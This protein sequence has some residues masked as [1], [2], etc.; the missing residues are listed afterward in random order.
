MKRY[1]CAVLL[2]V[3]L[4]AAR[5]AP[6]QE[7]VELVDAV[8]P[9]RDGIPQVS[10]IRLRKLLERNPPEPERTQA[11]LKLA[12]ALLG[13]DQPNEALTLLTDLAVVPL[14]GVTFLQAQAHAALGHW[15][16]ALTAY[17]T[18]AADAASPFKAEAAYGQS[19]ALRSL[20]RGDEALRVLT[21]LQNDAR[22]SVAARLRSVELLIEKRDLA[23]AQR[24]LETAAAGSAAEKKER[25]FLRGRIALAE[26]N[27]NRAIELF[28]SILKTPRGATHPVLIATLIGI[29]DAHLQSNKPGAGDDF[30]EDFIEHHPADPDLPTLFAKLD[31]LYAAERRQSRHDLGRWA[32]DEGRPRRSLS[33]WY[34]ARA[35]LRL[36]HP[37]LA[38]AAFQ[39]LE[40]SDTPLPEASL[41]HAQLEAQTGRA[42]EAARVLD[43]LR[44]RPSAARML[45]RI[46]MR[47]G[48][49]E[50]R[51]QHF[52]S[53]ARSFEQVAKGASTFARA[54]AYDLSL[55]WIEQGDAAQFAAATEKVAQ[56]SGGTDDAANL[57]LEQALVQAARQ[58]QEAADS[59]RRFLRDFPQH[60]RASDAWV[61]LGELAFH[62]A[63]PRLDE[64]ML[65]LRHAMESHP[66]AMA[67]E[68]ADYLE[69]WLDDTTPGSDGAKVIDSA[70]RFLGKYPTSTRAGEVRLKLAETYFRRQDFPGAQTQFELLAQQNPASPEAEKAQFFAGQAAM[71]SMNAGSLD[72]ALILF[73][74]VVKRN[75]ELKWAARNEQAVIERKIGKPQD[76]L[77]LYDE[78]IRGDAKPGEKREALC[79]KADVLYELGAASPENY[80]RAIALYDE[81]ATQ[82]DVSAHW[83]NQAL[84][85]KAMCLEKLAMPAEALA[86][87]YQVVDDERR[88]ERQREFFWFYKAGF[89]AARLLEEQSSW[90]PAAAIYEK[91]AFAG[92][93]R[94]EE[95]KSRLNRLRLEHF[96][97]EQ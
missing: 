94:S 72:R 77:T 64:A 27:R 18:V 16:E 97:W 8:Q 96:L 90:Q 51:A 13:A 19:V 70:N 55:G 73:D 89:N 30:L 15:T 76:A 31:Q 87:F 48:E 42:D 12:E 59:L 68:R 84:F 50:Y 22:W 78:V 45:D 57:L 17:Q 79:A 4:L 63:P 11:K 33:L 67:A 86:T 14:G 25:R 93:A 32:N 44:Q 52:D 5:N 65:D 6:A 7:S 80:R 40:T 95:A 41:E 66:T 91:L 75:G 47:A 20:G 54:A 24:L 26:N 21:S 49:L 28:Q 88:P 38:L 46:N 53:A 1:A 37:D 2:T 58:Q 74:A 62:A 69:I 10:V 36:G 81:L 82:K 92:G 43:A 39:Q 9:L 85:K 83:R 34:L 35:E 3:I 23:A 29:A 71:Q 61:A 60:E 56:Q